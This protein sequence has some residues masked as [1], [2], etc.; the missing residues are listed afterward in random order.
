MIGAAMDDGA[1]WEKREAKEEPMMI[2]YAI[3]HSNDY[4]LDEIRY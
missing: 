4:F 3:V 1:F 2:L